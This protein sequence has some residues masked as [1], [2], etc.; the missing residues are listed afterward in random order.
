MLTL[1]ACASVVEVGLNLTRLHTENTIFYPEL[2]PL[3]AHCYNPMQVA[4]GYSST[5]RARRSQCRGWGF[6]SPYLHHPPARSSPIHSPP[7]IALRPRDYARRLIR[8]LRDR[9]IRL[10]LSPRKPPRQIQTAIGVMRCT[11]YRANR[12]RSSA[13]YPQRLLTRQH[14]RNAHPS[15]QPAPIL[16]Y[17]CRIAF[18]QS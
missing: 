3:G 14:P 12:I 5:G 11:C 13:T 18:Y 16:I 8:C 10:R 15:G 2:T 6:K 17:S 1:S 9:R 7:D 4:W